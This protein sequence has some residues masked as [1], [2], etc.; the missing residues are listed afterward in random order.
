MRRTGRL[1]IATT[2]VVAMLA[3]G[4]SSALAAKPLTEHSGRYTDTFFDDFIFE[5]CGI[6]TMTTITEVWTLTTYADGSQRF[7]TSRTFISEDPR[8]PIERGA[9]M[10]TWDAAGVQTIHGS[11]VRLQRPGGGVYLLDAGRI[12]LSDPPVISGPHP[13]LDADLVEAYC[14]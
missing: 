2:M 12:V 13:F 4:A 10:S 9:G 8:L 11:P 6:E 5:L 14:P 3:A 1:F 7:H